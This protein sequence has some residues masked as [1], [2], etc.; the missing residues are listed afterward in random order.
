MITVSGKVVVDKSDARSILKFF[1]D[2]LWKGTRK[3]FEAKLESLGFL[4]FYVDC[5]TEIKSRGKV[6]LPLSYLQSVYDYIGVYLQKDCGEVFPTLLEKYK[7]YNFYGDYSKMIGYSSIIE[8]LNK[9]DPKVGKIILD[10]FK[11]VRL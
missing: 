4:D 6:V 11:H 10:S 1:R 9:V 8:D 5:P 3:E 2:T 7:L